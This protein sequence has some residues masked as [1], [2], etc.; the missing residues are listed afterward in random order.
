MAEVGGEHRSEPRMGEG[1]RLWEAGQSPKG[2]EC[3]CSGSG[4]PTHR[5]WELHPQGWTWPTMHV[6]TTMRR[7]VTRLQTSGPSPGAGVWFAGDLGNPTVDSGGLGFYSQL[8]LKL[9]IWL[10]PSSFRCLSFPIHK[11]RQLDREHFP[12]ISSPKYRTCYRRKCYLIG[13]L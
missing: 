5:S 12:D 10:N 3:L 8:G 9:S 7:E 1:A 4:G 6:R 13:E 2:G 11:M